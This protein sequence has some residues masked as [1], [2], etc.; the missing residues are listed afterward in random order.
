M[1]WNAKPSGGYGITSAEGLANVEQIDTY[2]SLE[3]FT[4]EA[5]AGICGNMY[6][7]SA[8]NP[9]RWEDDTVSYSYGYGLFQ[10]TPASG[11][12]PGCSNVSGYAPN[13]STSSITAGALPSDGDAQLYVMRHD[14]LHKWKSTC[15]RTYWDV[16]QYPN[17][18]ALRQYILDTWGNGSDITLDQFSQIDDIRS[19][20]FAFLACYEG[21]GAIHLAPRVANAEI[22]YPYLT[23]GSGDD[24][25]AM[26]GYALMKKRRR[27]GFFI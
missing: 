19:A 22:I 15:W 9:W 26:W 24:D 2:F 21:P 10:F 18:R 1:A 27:R 6:A 7:E 17:E 20:T 3:G 25:I 5:I 12:I 23:G 16:N 8:F 14:V 4:A 11:Y 13:L